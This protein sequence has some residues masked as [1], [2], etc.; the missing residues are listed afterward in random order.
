M[1]ESLDATIFEENEQ[2]LLEQLN[3]VGVLKVYSD[4][5]KMICFGDRNA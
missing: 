3:A 1:L 4:A 5:T 2:K